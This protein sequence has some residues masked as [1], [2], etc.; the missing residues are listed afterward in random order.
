MFTDKVE[1]QDV[2]KL[3]PEYGNLLRRVL[4]IQADCE[5]GGPHLY[6]KDCLLTAPTDTDKLIVARTA[7]EEIDHFRKICHLANELGVDTSYLLKR[8]NMERYVEAFRDVISTWEDYAVFG[9]LIDRVGRY[10]LEEYVGGSY[11]PLDRLMQPMLLEEQGHIAHGQEETARMA[12]SED[13]EQR[14]R[15]QE[16]LNYWYPKGLDMFGNSESRRSERFQY[17]GLKRRTN[18]EAR[19]QYIAEVNPLIEEMGLQVPDEKE[20]RKYF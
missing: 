15:I 6:I 9:F 18:A 20:G 7:A 19:A 5:I 3:D 4:Q 2:D 8:S 13:P 11:L 14:K 16:R 17:W 12:R 1:A 10:Q